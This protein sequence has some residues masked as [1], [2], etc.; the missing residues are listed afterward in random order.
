MLQNVC[1]FCQVSHPWGCFFPL[2]LPTSRSFAAPFT[3]SVPLPRESN[4][5]QEFCYG[6][7]LLNSP[8]K[9]VVRF[10]G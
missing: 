9:D 10:V 8:L 3:H 7:I 6:S 1:Y 4:R 2:S 5:D